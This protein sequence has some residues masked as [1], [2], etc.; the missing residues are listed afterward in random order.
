[1]LTNKRT[2]LTSD[3]GLFATLCVR[4]DRL[5]CQAPELTEG[6]ANVNRARDCTR[7]AR[8]IG[9]VD[10]THA[11]ARGESADRCTMTETCS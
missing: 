5:S 11:S 1:M 9:Q 7:K 2:L 10:R 6:L 8:S 3:T 4:E